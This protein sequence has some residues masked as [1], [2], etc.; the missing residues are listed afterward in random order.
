[1]GRII[2]LLAMGRKLCGGEDGWLSA[3]RTKW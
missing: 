2:E 3:A 1:M